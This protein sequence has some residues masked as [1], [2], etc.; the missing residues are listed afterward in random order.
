MQSQFGGLTKLRLLCLGDE[1][2]FVL[3]QAL[4]AFR[5][6]RRLIASLIKLGAVSNLF[7]ISN[8]AFFELCE[9]RFVKLDYGFQRQALELRHARNRVC[10]ES[11]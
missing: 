2:P 5:S 6:F 1:L 10:F 4:S 11:Y 7:G 3:S 9:I 8:A